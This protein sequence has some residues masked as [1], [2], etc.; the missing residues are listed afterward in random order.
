[1]CIQFGLFFLVVQLFA[2]L[3]YDWRVCSKLAVGVNLSVSV[4]GIDWR[5]VQ[6][7]QCEVGQAAGIVCK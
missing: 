3:R 5:S 6:G 1:M 4:P 7:A 2:M